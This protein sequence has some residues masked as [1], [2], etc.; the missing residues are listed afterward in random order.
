MIALHV[1]PRLTPLS[2]ACLPIRVLVLLEEIA[3]SVRSK[4]RNAAAFCRHAAVEILAS[5]RQQ[6]PT[7]A[8][9]LGCFY[10]TKLSSETI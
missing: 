1:R 6:W 4:R 7:T 5:A 10:L 8:P 9:R 2:V 3:V